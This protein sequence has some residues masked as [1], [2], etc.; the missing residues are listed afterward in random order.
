MK[1]WEWVLT[2]ILTA[3]VPKEPSEK[4]ENTPERLK[5]NTLKK[6]RTK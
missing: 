5:L 6:C 3:G 4:Y 1:I 2:L